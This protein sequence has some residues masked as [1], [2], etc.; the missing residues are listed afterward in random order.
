MDAL[1]RTSFISVVDLVS[2][3][4]PPYDAKPDSFRLEN[5]KQWH[6]QVFHVRHKFTEP[7]PDGLLQ[8]G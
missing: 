6:V 4:S 7:P 1:V 8:Y 2:V 3:E 5:I